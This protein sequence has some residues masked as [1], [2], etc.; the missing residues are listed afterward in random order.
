M[1]RLF[2]LIF[3]FVILAAAYYS[4]KQH[5][6]PAIFWHPVKTQQNI[7]IKFPGDPKHTQKIRD[8]PIIGQA[9]L[10]IYQQLLDDDL[11]V[12]IE[13]KARDKDLTR[14]NLDE[15]ETA[16]FALNG[17]ENLRISNKHLFELHAYPSIDYV[18]H[19]K[20]GNLIYCRTIKVNNQLVSMI[21]ASPVE[22]FSKKRHKKFFDSLQFEK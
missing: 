7:N 16:I 8:F 1:I 6:E 12:L 11:F 9:R 20:K 18:A 19:D 22:Q 21:Y 3:V 15:L 5:S 2:K 17:T 4:F 14:F 10:Q 13:L